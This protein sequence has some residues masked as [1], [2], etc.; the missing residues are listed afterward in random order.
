[1]GILRF[2]GGKLTEQQGTT[3][4]AD[5]GNEAVRAFGRNEKSGPF[6]AVSVI[7]SERSKFEFRTFEGGQL[8]K[9]IRRFPC[10]FLATCL[11]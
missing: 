7:F 11:G 3:Q 4:R 9:K 8:N 2:D 6:S 1:M 10:G 5:C